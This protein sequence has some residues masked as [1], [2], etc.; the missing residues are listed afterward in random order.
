MSVY[1]LEASSLIYLETIQ[2]LKTFDTNLFRLLSFARFPNGESTRECLSA[3]LFLLLQ[4]FKL[5]NLSQLTS[6][7]T[8][9]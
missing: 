5:S 3:K 4:L 9:K 6:R 8:Q 7:L 2:I 1:L